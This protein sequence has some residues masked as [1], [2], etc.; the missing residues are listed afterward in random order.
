[1][2]YYFCSSKN[3]DLDKNLIA[4]L[5]TEDKKVWIKDDFFIAE[6]FLEI[7]AFDSGY[8]IIK[9]KDEKISHRFKEYFQN[10]AIDLQKFNEKY[11]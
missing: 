6:S 9:F 1:M 10:E 3:I 11:F 2:G 7:V 5:P 4:E 8:T